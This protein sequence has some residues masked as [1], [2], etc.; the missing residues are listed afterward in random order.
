VALSR[1]NTVNPSEL[2]CALRAITGAAHL[3]EGPDTTPYVTEW[4]GRFRGDALCAVKPADRDQVAAIVRL[5]AQH[6]APLLPQGGNTSMSGG[7]VPLAASEA[8]PPVILNLSRLRRIRKVDALN[9]SLEADAGCTV[10]DIQAAAEAVDRLYGVSFGAEG[11]AQIGGSV[12]TNAGGTGVLRYGNT[13]DNVLGLEVVLPD[14]SI[15]EGLRT[16]RKD[17]TGYD[18]KQLFIGSEG[19]LGVITAVALK[20]HPRP[21]AQAVAW[22]APHSLPAALSLLALAQQQ[23]G[24][25]LNAFEVLNRTQIEHVMAHVPGVREPLAQAAPWNLLI[26]LSERGEPAALQDR[27]EQLLAQAEQS[28][29]IADATVASNQAQCADFW[30][31]RSSVSEGNRKS[32][33][34][35]VFDVAVPLVQVPSF[36]DRASAAVRA[37]IDTAR[38]PVVGHLGDGNMHLVIV[39]EWAQWHALPEPQAL[40][41]GVREAVYAIAA[42][43]GGTW[44]AEHGIGSLLLAQMQQYKSPIELQLMHSIKATLDPHGLFNPGKLLPRRS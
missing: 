1:L 3:L 10:A 19:T 25:S 4:R 26:E 30:R 22:V 44:S 5:C 35:L 28:G 41:Q 39:I 15:W 38:I 32:G 24:S 16:L 8:T 20:L 12:A 42:E 11:S 7:S 40:L 23:C 36:I 14:G 13:R 17:N 34:S 43:L 37:L 31:I 21:N 29:L 6:R 2:I 33:M 27:L 18:L 9:H